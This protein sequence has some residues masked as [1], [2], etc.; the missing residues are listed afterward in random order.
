MHSPPLL[1][2]IIVTWNSIKYLSTCLE[3]LLTQTH[4]DFEVILVDNGS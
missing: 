3:H 4:R 2:V 1:S